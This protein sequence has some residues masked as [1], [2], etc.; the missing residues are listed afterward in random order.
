MADESYTNGPI[1]DLQPPQASRRSH[2]KRLIAG[3]VLIGILL[4][5]IGAWEIWHTGHNTTKT[6]STAI[7]ISSKCP[8]TADTS[9]NKTFT[10]PSD[11][12]WYTIKDIGIKYAYPKDWTQ[13]TTQTNSGLQKY[14]ASF[15]VASLGA[16]ATVSLRPDC[17][18]FQTNITAINSGTFDLLSGPTTTRAT[19]HS[20][21]S[22]SSLSHWTSDPG[23]Q[24]QLVNS[25]IVNVG[26]IRSAVLTYGIIS[27][28][29]VCPDDKLATNDQTKCITQS[30]SDELD[31]VIS[32]LQKI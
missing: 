4:I 7:T 28:S 13:P 30:I 26:S 24:Y 8:I 32:S 16:S 27:G 19:Q 3:L 23:N 25:D 14:V 22:Y 10:L 5:A 21:T 1:P 9:T 11:W 6:S 29:Q 17:S 12:S 15:T 31:K 2:K 18:D 20:Q